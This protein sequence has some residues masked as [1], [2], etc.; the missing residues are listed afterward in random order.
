MPAI[1]PRKKPRGMLTMQ[2]ITSKLKLSC[3]TFFNG[4]PLV[5]SEPIRGKIE[6]NK[7]KTTDAARSINIP[8][9]ELDKYSLILFILFMPK[10]IKK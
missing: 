2:R 3:K 8:F 9:R 10:V 6:I 4:K 1:I 7:I 5:V